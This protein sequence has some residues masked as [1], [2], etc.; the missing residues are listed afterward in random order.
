MKKIVRFLIYIMILALPLSAAQSELLQQDDVKKI[1]QQILSQHL[2]QQAMTEKVLKNSFEVFIDQFDPVRIYLL[3]DEVAP[4]L[5]LTDAQV[6]ELLEQY[7]VDNFSAYTSLNTVIQK[8]ILRARQVRKGLETNDNA[9]FQEEAPEP[10]HEERPFARSESQLKRRIEDHILQFIISEEEG[11]GVQK[12]QAHKQAVLANYEDFIRDYE[13]QYLYQEEGGKP[14]PIAKQ[15]NLFTM[16]VIK[17]L[18]KSLDSHTSFYDAEE[19]YDMKIRL[20]KGFYGIGIIPESTTDGVFV[21]RILAGSPAAKQGAIQPG[22]LILSVN[23]TSTKTLP[24]K[25][26]TDLF[27]STKGTSISLTLKRDNTPYKVTLKSDLIIVNEDR[28]DVLSQPY[29]GGIIGVIALHSFY[30]GKGGIT[31]EKDVRDAILTLNQENNLKGLVLDLR[32]N[33]GGFLTE[34]V[35]V[36]GLFI[37]NGVVVIS[38]YNDGEEHFYR[39]MDNRVYFD[40]PLVVLTSKGTASAAEIVAQALQDYG[41][42]VIVGDEHT[43]GKGTIQSQTITN[44]NSSSYFKV[45]VGT[46]YTVSGKTPQLQ[47]VKSD[48]V[49]PSDLLYQNVGEEY[50]ENAIDNRQTVPNAYADNLADIDPGLKPWFLRY[51]TPTLQGR[52]ANWQ[53]ALPKLRENS[54]YR[55]SRDPSYQKFFNGGSI[56]LSSKDSDPQLQEAIHIVEDMVD[57][58]PTK[59]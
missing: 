25:E 17:A 32:N 56:T 2:D 43:Y 22:D 16:H 50:L 8:A 55:L 51:Y 14:L 4:F 47:G 7:R 28:M 3:E 39:D 26:I 11:F 1:M 57:L 24:A 20:E 38:K 9:L 44:E 21:R 33:S 34:A 36:A 46:Y 40:G 5:N 6:Q 41:V 30:K 37:T 54:K 27:L 10:I 29:R 45:T 18:A 13:D 53:E 31:S 49:V 23:G 58:Q 52:S 19:A 12:I 42:A 15:E 48:I 59:K 35:K